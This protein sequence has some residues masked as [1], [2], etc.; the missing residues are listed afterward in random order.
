MCVCGWVCCLSD[1]I[2]N[3]WGL[4]PSLLRRNEH[5]TWLLADF[6]QCG[7][8]RLLQT[9]CWGGFS[10]IGRALYTVLIINV[11]FF[12][13]K[14]I[15]STLQLKW[16]ATLKRCHCYVTCEMFVDSCQ[17]I[18]TVPVFIGDMWSS[19][20]T[21]ACRWSTTW[22]PSSSLSESASSSLL[23]SW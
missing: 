16:R 19:C 8:K 10:E 11:G 21:S 13:T 3:P 9:C 18:M 20:Q 1:T 6:S 15:F 2:Q 4:F 14:I 7:P 22:S 5:Q 12:Y 23:F 17:L